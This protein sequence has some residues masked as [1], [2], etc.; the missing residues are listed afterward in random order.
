LL[1]V[2]PA[3]GPEEV[4]WQ[5]LWFNHQQRVLRGWLTAPFAV[6]VVLLPVSGLTSAIS[7]LNS[8]VRDGPKQRKKSKGSEAEEKR[9]HA[10][11]RYCSVAHAVSC[12][13]AAGST[14][15]WHYIYQQT[16]A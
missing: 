2:H 10:V 8:E 11:T 12:A 7:M 14:P 15:I 3:P 6:I 9:K 1:Q 5:S 16:D 13:C 4:N